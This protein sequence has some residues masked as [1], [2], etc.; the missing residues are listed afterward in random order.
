MGSILLGLL[1]GFGLPLQT[2]INS[3]LG[4]KV[5][6][7]F[8]SSLISFTVGTFFLAFFVMLTNPHLALSWQSFSDQPWWLWIGGILGVCYLTANIVLFPHLGSVQTVIMP[9]S[10]QIIMSMLID[11]FGWFNSQQHQLSWSRILGAVIVL[12]GVSLAV[13]GQKA[14]AKSPLH[15]NTHLNLWRLVGVA[16]GMLSA[17][18]TAI[19]GHLGIILHSSAQAALV[20]FGIG[21]LL[22]WFIVP[23]INHGY[24][25]HMISHAN[26][27]WWN[28]LGGLV[29]GLYVLTNAYLVPILGTGLTIVVVLVGMISG[30]L[31]SDNFGWLHSQQKKI[32]FNQLLGLLIL[33]AGVA[34][35]KLVS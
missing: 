18:Q 21:T 10:G 24:H 28:W 9:V 6:S 20:S 11:H 8:L 22:L 31:L 7:S 29:G 34:L 13:A 32:N 14:A 15:T 4:K 27:S 16:A 19:N 33:L 35:I 5:K 2:A 17:T 3:D 23:A 25:F 12:G 1:A 30:S 26:I